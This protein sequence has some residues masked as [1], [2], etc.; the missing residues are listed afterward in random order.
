MFHNRTQKFV[1]DT[2]CKATAYA[3]TDLHSD[4]NEQ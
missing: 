1:N 4:R 3:E 2:E